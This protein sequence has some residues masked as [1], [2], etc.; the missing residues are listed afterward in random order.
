MKKQKTI[1]EEKLEKNKEKFNYFK[2]QIKE[3]IIP[4]IAI[5]IL[6][7]FT[8]GIKLLKYSFSIDTEA[9][10]INRQ[11]LLESW[12][13]IGRYGL[14]FIKQIIDLPY[15]NLYLA[16]IIG[17]ILLFLTTLVCIYNINK[18]T[19][20]NNKIANILLG[21]LIITSPIMVEQFNFTLQCVEV[22]LA[23]LLLN[24]AFSILNMC[25]INKNKYYLLPLSIAMIILA[26]SCYQS[27]I[28]LMITIS[29]FFI[30]I[31]FKE[32]NEDKISIIIKYA[33]VFIIALIFYEIIYMLVIKFT[34]VS[35]TTYLTSQILW[36]T[37]RKIVIIKDIVNNILRVL[38]GTAREHYNLGLL[39]CIIGFIPF[40][41]KNFK[42]KNWVFYLSAITFFASPFLLIILTGG[43]PVVR[44]EVQ[45]TFATALGSYFIYT[46]ADKKI[47]KCI[48]IMLFGIVIM[49]QMI[50]SVSLF[51]TDY[52][53]FE[54]EKE[55][56]KNIE[57]D[58][59]KKRLQDKPIAFVGPYSAKGKDIILKG[60]VMGYTFFEWDQGSPMDS[61]VR[62]GGFL[63][64]LG[65][66]L[67]SVNNDQ[68]IEAK[69][70]AKE[71][72]EIYPNEGYIK[73][74]DDYVI[75]KLNN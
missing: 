65:Y 69:E 41:I 13:S 23:L 18:I 15:I 47:T 32:K 62:I 39:F 37:T 66:N 12:I 75:V 11:A 16:N 30:M 7:L 51:Y 70:K 17:F 8:Y 5:L 43:E 27:F 26:F 36:G 34:G 55:L 10:L 64:V 72:T 40:I 1:N 56:A 29:T 50:T 53:V 2:E 33:V 49:Q 74:E 68:Y 14:V 25:I 71:M 31:L 28:P 20:K 4:I 35:K 57:K 59:T 45:I 44:T 52:K 54:Q 63:K 6:G 58:L 21:G 46:Y 38:L 60:E 22:S 48:I 67:K 3:N 61:N 42:I 9:L 24:I 19:N 73:E